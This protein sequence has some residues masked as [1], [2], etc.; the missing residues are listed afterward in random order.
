M[1]WIWYKSHVYIDLTDVYCP[2]C[3]NAGLTDTCKVLFCLFFSVVELLFFYVNFRLFFFLLFRLLHIGRREKSDHKVQ[4][5][6]SLTCSL[7]RRKTLGENNTVSFFFL[8]W[9]D[10][11][12]PHLIYNI[13]AHNT[14]VNTTI[15]LFFLPEFPVVIVWFV[16]SPSPRI[17]SFLMWSHVNIFFQIPHWH[18]SIFDFY[19]PNLLQIYSITCYFIS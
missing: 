3:C 10:V 9:F 7:T 12:F 19:H 2:S 6:N 1:V 13:A 14:A 11:T 18:F 16:P 5:S 17:G 8:L 4:F 15:K